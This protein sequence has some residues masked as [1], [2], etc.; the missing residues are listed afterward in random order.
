MNISL[1]YPEPRVHTRTDVAFTSYL[2][3]GRLGPHLHCRERKKKR[4][5]KRSF[6]E[7]RIRVQGDVREVNDEVARLFPKKKGPVK[8]LQIQQKIPRSPK[9][10]N[11]LPYDLPEPFGRTLILPVERRGGGGAG[12]A[13]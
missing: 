9:A 1:G 12:T 11:S 5:T 13:I 3:Q 7:G 2:P 10:K 4:K 6:R 8:H